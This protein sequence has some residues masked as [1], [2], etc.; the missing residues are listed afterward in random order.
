M[1]KGRELR[2]RE[3]YIVTDTIRECTECSKIFKKMSHTVTLC[4]ECN[5]NRVKATDP[6]WKMHQRAKQRARTNDREFSIQVSDIVFPDVCP[7][8]GMSLESHSGSSGGKPNSPALDR[9]DNLKGYTKENIQVVSHRANQMKLDA[10]KEELISF[11]K[12]VLKTFDT[13]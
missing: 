9:I 5:S 13:E 7:I 3:G 6:R 10:S 4:N 12:W 8:L 1:Q 11:A 2:N